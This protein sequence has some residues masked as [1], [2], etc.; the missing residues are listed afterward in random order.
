MYINYTFLPVPN[1]L[2]GKF[3]FI[4]SCS[5]TE[6]LNLRKSIDR[7]QIVSQLPEMYAKLISI[8]LERNKAFLEGV[9]NSKGII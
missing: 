3:C 2:D 1:A 8:F 4:D 6:V 9:L 5:K 7:L